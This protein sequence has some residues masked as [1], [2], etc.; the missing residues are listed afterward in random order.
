M[1]LPKLETEILGFMCG[2]EAGEQLEFRYTAP[3]AVI[4]SLKEHGRLSEDRP[5]KNGNAVCTAI[6]NRDIGP[7]HAYPVDT[8]EHQI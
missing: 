7:N 4:V 1:L 2:F 3:A 5:G 6:I 8:Q